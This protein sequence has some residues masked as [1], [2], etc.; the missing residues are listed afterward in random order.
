MKKYLTPTLIFLGLFLVLLGTTLFTIYETERGIIVRL[1]DLQ[2]DSKTGE[3]RLLEPGLH[4]KLPFI[5]QLHVFDSRLNM[6]EIPSER[7]LT[8]DKE[9]LMVDLFIQWRITDYPLFYNSTYGSNEGLGNRDRAEQLLR[10]TV[11]GVLHAE[12]GQRTLQSVVSGERKQLMQKLVERTDENVRRYGMNIVDVRV[13]RVD[14]P[15]EVN[16]KVFARMISERKQVAAGFRANGEAKA[17]V[18]RAEADK[19]TRIMIAEAEKQAE[20]LRGEGDA[21]ALQIYA[22]SYNKAP[23]F[24][25][26]YRS[27]EAYR[28]SFQDKQDVLVLKPD[29][30]FFKYFRGNTGGSGNVS[31]T[32]NTSNTA[33]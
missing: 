16:D 17:A 6:T 2:K 4:A 14:Y 7:I 11:K 21:K 28:K 12:F 24:F 32:G 15:P 31:N 9:L 1:G 13:N 3:V 20:A 18:I 33:R 25:E 23:E 30:P 26:F 22:D 27:L 29:G 8:K 10:Q 19:T 5:D